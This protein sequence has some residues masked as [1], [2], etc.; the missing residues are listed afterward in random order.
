M[1]TEHSVPN[2]RFSFTVIPQG[3]SFSRRAVALRSNSAFNLKGFFP[4]RGALTEKGE[5]VSNECR[6]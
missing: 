6:E 1:T 4:P 2:L 3:P 5:A